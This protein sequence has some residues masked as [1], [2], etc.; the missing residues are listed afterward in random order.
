MCGFFCEL[1][2]AYSIIK[3]DRIY[4]NVITAVKSQKI[5]D[6]LLVKSSFIGEKE[7]S[8]INNFK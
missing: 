2:S 4:F 6:S 5:I 8:A 1:R 7:R 3:G